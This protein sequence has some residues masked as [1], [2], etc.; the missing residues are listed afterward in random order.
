MFFTLKSRPT[1]TGL[2]LKQFRHTENTVSYGLRK[3]VVLATGQNSPFGSVS[4]SD[5]EPDRCNGLPHKSAL[6]QSTFLASVKYLSSHHI[7]K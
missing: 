7:A 5:L 2:F 1:L 6:Q 3:G 4:G